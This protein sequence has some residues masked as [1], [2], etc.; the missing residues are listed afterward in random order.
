MLESD[1]L[2]QFAK[3]IGDVDWDIEL[4]RQWSNFFDEK[5]H[6]P[7]CPSDERHNQRYRLRTHGLMYFENPLPAFPRSNDPAGVYTSDFSR[8]GC[9]ILSSVP[10]FPGEEVR[11]LLPTFWTTLIVVRVRRITQRCFEIGLTLNRRLDP[12]LDA[13]GDATADSLVQ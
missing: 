6:T 3:L 10:L 13:F 1:Y 11:V 4:P 12:S 9:G 2:A 5:G 8:Q 7:S